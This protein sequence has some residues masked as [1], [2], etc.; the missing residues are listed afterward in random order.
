MKNMEYHAS[1]L[2]AAK[3]DE[4]TKEE[5]TIAER[6]EKH[7]KT[8]DAITSGNLKDVCRKFGRYITSSDDL[9]AKIYLKET[10]KEI[11]ADN[12]DVQLKLNIA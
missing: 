3:L 11:V 2:L 10:I 6:L 5:A 8:G 4:L 7:K 9:E 12:E 1:A